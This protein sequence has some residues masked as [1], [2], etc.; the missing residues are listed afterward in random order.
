MAVGAHALTSL[1]KLK[2][3]MRIT[4]SDDDT[5]L[6]EIIDS[7]SA[8]IQTVTGRVFNDF[9]YRE[10]RNGEIQRRMMLK[11]WPVNSINRISYGAGNAFHLKFTSSTSN[12][13]NA[14]F[15]KADSGDSTGGIR[16]VTFNP[17]TDPASR[18]VT[19]LA[20]SDYGSVS[21]LVAAIN[22][23]SGWTAT[24]DTNVPTPDINPIAGGDCYNK[25][26]YFTY[27]DIDY[28]D[29]TVDGERGLVEFMTY[30]D[31]VP[32]RWG[33]MRYEHDLMR[34]RPNRL[35]NL[36]IE[37]NAGYTTIPAD[38]ELVCH[39]IASVKYYAGVDNPAIKSESLG[40]YSVTFSEDDHH[41]IRQKLG[42]YIDGRA[43]IGG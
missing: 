13:A 29:F 22:E 35:Q 15:Y 4:S 16:L 8:L 21:L 40:P 17:T 25:D 10:R 41:V 39:E 27:P 2:R 31:F 1:V 34:Y 32:D 28:H 37:Y 5:L 26:L 24:T 9:D 23:V 33:E 38:V 7:T 42:M 30:R 36:L 11:H 20:F 18:T 6:E 12:R 43:L 3:F 19:S 14:S